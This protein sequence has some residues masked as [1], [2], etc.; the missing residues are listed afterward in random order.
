MF[1]RIRPISK[2][3]Q[4][5]AI[6]RVK[7]S[8]HAWYYSPSSDELFEH[9]K[10][11]FHSHSQEHYIDVDSSIFRT[12]TTRKTI[13]TKKICP[14]SVETMR[15][16]IAMLSFEKSNKNI[17]REV[18]YSEELVSLLLERNAD[19]LRQSTL[20]KIPSQRHHSTNAPERRPCCILRRYLT[21]CF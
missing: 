20:K 4:T 17:W 3:T 1:R 19:H 12:Q 16:G 15:S 9:R 7:V 8:V 11:V 14:V 2:R 5:G 18:T 10:G 13:P 6:T 21:H